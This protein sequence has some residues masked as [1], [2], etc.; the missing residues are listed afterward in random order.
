M[1]AM[2]QRLLDEGFEATIIETDDGPIVILRDPA[3]D[4]LPEPTE[5]EEWA[6]AHNVD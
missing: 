2:T 1:D 6:V 4:E 5:Y 3:L